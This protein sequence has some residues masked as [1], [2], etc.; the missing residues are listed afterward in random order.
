[1]E[2]P[3]RSDMLKSA[4]INWGK[5]FETGKYAHSLLISPL[6]GIVRDGET[7]ARQNYISADKWNLV[8]GAMSRNSS[9]GT[10]KIVN[11]EWINSWET[12]EHYAYNLL[13]LNVAPMRKAQVKCIYTLLNG[14]KDG[15]VDI[16]SFVCF[17][18]PGYHSMLEDTTWIVTGRH[19]DID[20]MVATLELL[21]VSGLPATHADMSLL[22][23]D[24]RNLL[25][26]NGEK[27]KLEAFYGR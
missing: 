14:L 17:A 20:R 24:G 5:D 25:L 1:M 3:D 6:S 21:E 26:E 22:L 8:F 23:E 12:A 7:S 15:P 2:S 27:I 18:L 13:R 9:F 16:G 4:T 19:D 11:S 10:D